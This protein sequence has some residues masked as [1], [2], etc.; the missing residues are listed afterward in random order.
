MLWFAIIM[1]LGYLA[2]GFI[3]IN[4]FVEI[5]VPWEESFRVMCRSLS[6]LNRA[7][8][9]RHLIHLFCGILLLAGRHEKHRLGRCH[10][11]SL[12]A[13][14]QCRGWCHYHERSGQQRTPRTRWLVDAFLYGMNLDLDWTAIIPEVNQK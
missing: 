8:F 13:I 1:G 12:M 7:P 5:F 14:F 6:R 2:Y 9:L 4:K 3:G 11:Y 10:Q